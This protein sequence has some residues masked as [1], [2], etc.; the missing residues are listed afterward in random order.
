[1]AKIVPFVNNMGEK[2]FTL[3]K[4]SAETDI[5]TARLCDLV[6]SQLEK[7]PRQVAVR[8][9]LNEA[10]ELL[11]NSKLTVDEIAERCHFASPNYFIASFYHYY[12][13]NPAEYR[14]NPL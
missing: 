13:V 3:D 12:R 7:N 9:R 6:A 5:D 1:M 2:T 11:R 8:M 14:K 10:E 4:L